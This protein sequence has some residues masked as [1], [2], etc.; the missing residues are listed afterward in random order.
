MIDSIVSLRIPEELAAAPVHRDKSEVALCAPRNEV[1]PKFDYEY[2]IGG[3]GTNFN[4][5]PARECGPF[6]WFHAVYVKTWRSYC[7]VFDA[8]S[9]SLY[10]LQITQNLYV[11][12]TKGSIVRDNERSGEQV[13][14]IKGLVL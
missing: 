14:W 8:A 4:G 5:R 3:V 6:S 13:G 12:D 10:F 2:N 11:I 1:R 7:N 9:T